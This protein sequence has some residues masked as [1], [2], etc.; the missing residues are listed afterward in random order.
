MNEILRRFENLCTGKKNTKIKFMDTIISPGESVSLALPLPEILG[1]APFYMPVK[2]IHG[3]TRGPCLLVFATMRGNEFNGME[4]IKRLM[5]VP[6]LKKIKGTIIAVPVLNVFGTMNRS[7]F[8]PGHHLL[9]TS[10]PGKELGDYASRLADLFMTEI[11]EKC[12]CCVEICSGELNHNT[13]S[14]VYTDLTYGM[15]KELAK[16][17]QVSVITG[18]RPIKGSLQFEAAQ[19]DIPMLTYKAGEAMRFNEKAIKLGIRGLMRLIRNIKMLPDY[20]KGGEIKEDVRSV[21]SE[22]TNWV[23]TQRSGIAHN[24]KKLGDK[25]SSGELLSR[26]SEPLGSF[27]EVDVIA[28]YEGVVVGI[29]EMPLVYEGEALYR[30]ASFDHNEEAAER[31]QDWVD[32]ESSI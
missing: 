7:K 17:F 24:Y 20:K 5:Q 8:V 15:N 10:F 18:N 14:Q 23:F 31:V 4:I 16:A 26:I 29:N 32:E 6:S 28:P 2:V 9:E 30:I 19:R 25:V 1:Y 11:F 21:F 27:Q 22:K 3:K 13:M 12:D